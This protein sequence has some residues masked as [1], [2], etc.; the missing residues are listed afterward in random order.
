M[1][2]VG[3]FESELLDVKRRRGCWVFRLDQNIRAEFVCHIG[4]LLSLGAVAQVGQTIAFR[5]LSRL[6]KVRTMTDDKKRSSVLLTFRSHA[7]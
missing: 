6:A 2:R 1:T 3:D 7:Q 4:S 5:G